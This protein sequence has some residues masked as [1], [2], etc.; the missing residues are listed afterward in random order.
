VC[1]PFRGSGA[2][3]SHMPP[4]S[5]WSEVKEGRDFFASADPVDW[6]VSNPPYSVTDRVLAHSA[7]RARRGFGYLLPLHAITPRRIEAMESAG[8]GL[9]TVHLCK[10]FRWYGMSAFCLWQT[11]VGSIIRY[12]RTVWR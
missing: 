9:S 10:V 11:G 8:F 5:P 7:S 12:D 1:D 4:G 2:F 3:H 6:F